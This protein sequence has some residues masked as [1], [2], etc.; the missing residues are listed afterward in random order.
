MFFIKIYNMRILFTILF[1]FILGAAYA[2]EPVYN[3]MRSN[4]QFK[5]VRV[6]SLLLFPK[7]NDTTAANNTAL[8][9]IAGNVIRVGNTVYYRSTDL[10]KWMTFGGGSSIDTTMLCL[11]WL[12]LHTII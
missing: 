12:T 2:Q 1:T 5:G 6:D 9:S 11:A 10:K 4:Y 3:Q 8:D 7:F